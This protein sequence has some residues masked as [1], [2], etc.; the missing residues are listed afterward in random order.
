MDAIFTHDGPTTVRMTTSRR[1]GRTRVH[2]FP[3][4]TG[5]AR[6]L[7]YLRTHLTGTRGTIDLFDA[8]ARSQTS[9]AAWT[10]WLEKSDIFTD[11]ATVR[12]T[13]MVNITLA[14][15]L[16]KTDSLPGREPHK[17]TLTVAPQI[18]A[19]LQADA[20]KRSKVNVVSTARPSA[21]RPSATVAPEQPAAITTPLT[22]PRPELAITITITLTTL[23]NVGI[24]LVL[25]VIGV[26]T[27]VVIS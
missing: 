1:A 15:S 14:S 24:G 2:R 8:T 25:F 11:V 7:A 3:T 21:G 23:R 20:V 10:S 19:Q 26:L 12:N 6:K 22:T 16:P 13:A 9:G 18:R 27:G 4:D 5:N 17:R